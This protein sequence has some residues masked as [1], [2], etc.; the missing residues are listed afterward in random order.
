[1]KSKTLLCVVL[2]FYGAV[3]NAAPVNQNAPLATWNDYT[4]K[5]KLE[6]A[7]NASVLCEK[8]SCAPLSIKRCVDEVA[9]PPIPEAARRERIGVVALGCVYTLNE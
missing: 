9:R 4:H 6:Y 3:V 8:P 1:M 5:E 2:A 7:T